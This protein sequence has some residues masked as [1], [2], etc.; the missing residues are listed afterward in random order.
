MIDEKSGEG[1]SEIDIV[2][3]F[4]WIGMICKSRVL[5]RVKVVPFL[6]PSHPA[7]HL[8]DSWLKEIPVVLEND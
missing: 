1:F 6:P 2:C 7:A 4:Q 3:L 5:S 8:L